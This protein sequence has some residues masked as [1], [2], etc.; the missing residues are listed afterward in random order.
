MR[1]LKQLIDV[2]EVKTMLSGYSEANL[3]LMIRS[4]PI[5]NCPRIVKA[6]K[7]FTFNSE[8]GMILEPVC[9]TNLS[10]LLEQ[11]SMLSLKVTKEIFFSLSDVG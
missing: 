6:F 7:I 5:T 9:A 4:N 3:E 11:S 10:G 8:I 2:S 1:L